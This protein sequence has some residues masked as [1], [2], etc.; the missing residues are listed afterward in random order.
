MVGFSRKAGNRHRFHRQDPVQHVVWQQAALA[1]EIAN[2]AS[3]THGCLGD[4]CSLSVTD[5][6]TQRSRERG[7]AIQEF[8]AACL[9]CLDPDD[10]PVG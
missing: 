5:I 10:A 8:T 3:R 1:H 7:A 6:R 9:V 2:A 4:V